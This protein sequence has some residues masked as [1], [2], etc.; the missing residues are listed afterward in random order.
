MF[1][2]NIYYEDTDAGG[3]VYYANYLKF[4]ERARTDFLKNNG[5][6]Q[7]VLAK[8]G[9]FFVVRKCE[10]DY[11]SSAKLDDKISVSCK[12]ENIERVSVDFSQEIFCQERK[13]ISAKVKIVCVK[14]INGTF[15]PTKISEYI[16]IK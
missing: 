13:L 16:N 3:V 4:L 10:I 11:L 6:F 8:E 5:I 15:K 14:N 1:E 2:Y 12:I 7:N 9:I